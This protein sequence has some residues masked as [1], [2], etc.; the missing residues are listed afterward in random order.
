MRP[1]CRLPKDDCGTPMRPILSERS[2]HTRI[3][4]ATSRVGRH[5]GNV[6]RI[7]VPFPPGESATSLYSCIYL[8]LPQGVRLSG[9]CQSRRGGSGAAV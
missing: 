9:R 4:T 6:F 2:G 1:I 7:S 8:Y 5:A 3:R